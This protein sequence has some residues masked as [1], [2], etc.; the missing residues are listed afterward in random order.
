MTHWS[1][2]IR[3]LLVKLSRQV[4]HRAKENL[5][6]V[7]RV[8]DSLLGIHKVLFG[9]LRAH[10]H[11]FWRA[12]MQEMTY[13][14]YECSETSMKVVLSKL[15][16]WNP[17]SYLFSLE[18]NYKWWWAE[19]YNR[20]TIW[21]YYVSNNLPRGINLPDCTSNNISLS[22]TNKPTWMRYV[23]RKRE[24]NFELSGENCKFTR[25]IF[26][27]FFIFIIFSFVNQNGWLAS[28][29]WCF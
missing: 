3:L 12:Y 5:L 10:Y 16:I 15:L 25:V 26:W 20:Y 9:V 18:W 8:F 11:V 1:F 28:T 19:A 4:S 13:G 2:S 7:K 27:I 17:L 14:L 24:G 29:K 22:N 23:F 6:V 21:Y